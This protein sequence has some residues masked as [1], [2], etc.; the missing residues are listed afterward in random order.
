MG[1]EISKRFWDIHVND[2]HSILPDVPSSPE[3]ESYE[4]WMVY[5]ITMRLQKNILQ[6]IDYMYSQKIITGEALGMFLKMKNTLQVAAFSRFSVV[7]PNWKEEFGNKE[8]WALTQPIFN[9]GW[10]S[11]NDKNFYEGKLK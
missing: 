6:T 7:Q 2:L 1:R 3:E 8:I 5:L 11:D 4:N 10:L 9:R